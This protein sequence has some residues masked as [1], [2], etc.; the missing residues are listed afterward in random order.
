MSRLTLRLPDSLH[1]QLERMAERERVSLNQHIVY[2]LTRQPTMQDTLAYTVQPVPETVIA[3][4]R[5]AY[6]ALR[7]A[8]GRASWQEIRQAL[9]AR[10]PR[11]TRRAAFPETEAA[12]RARI[13][14][15]RGVKTAA[16]GAFRAVV[17]PGASALLVADGRRRGA[18]AYW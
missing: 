2:A 13:A 16:R 6:Q 5:A 4:E 10:E 14:A 12:L 11:R 1:Q 7:Q 18:S 8:L 15:Q 17:F 9:E 3:E